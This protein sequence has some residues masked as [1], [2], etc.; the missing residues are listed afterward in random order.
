MH[1]LRTFI[2]FLA[3]VVL[4]F[5]AIH[6]FGSKHSLIGGKATA[7]A[8][9]AIKPIDSTTL[10]N[11]VQG[12]INNN[13]NLDISVSATDLQTGKSYH[14]GETA[15]FAGA[16][17]GKLVTAALFLHQTET[18][19]ATLTQQINGANAQNELQQLIV[20]SDNDAWVAFNDVLGHDALDSY[21]H[22][23]GMNSYDSANDTMTS[24]DVALLLQKL[25]K[26]QLL[27][28]S[29]TKLLLSYLQ[30]A[31]MRDYIVASAPSGATVYHKVGY[32]DDRLHDAAIIQK[33][34]R[35]I[36]LVIF[37]KTGDDSNY[38]FTAGAQLFGQLTKA[39]DALFFPGS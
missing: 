37:S 23:L 35:S 15:A 29:N 21:A 30:Q 11:A 39:A 14:Y 8:A 20:N 36:V 31:N 6:L 2:T 28:A 32:L 17:I 13:A 25:D 33:G 19:D 16:S 38:D 10:A 26:G 34:G 24:D 9:P 18:G 5:G 1:K 3:I 27:N 12:V 22:G 7:H 4:A